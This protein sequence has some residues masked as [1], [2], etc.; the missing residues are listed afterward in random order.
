MRAQQSGDQH[1]VERGHGGEEFGQSVDRLGQQIDSHHAT[2]AR[3]GG[4]HCS[5][6]SGVVPGASSK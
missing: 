1:L 4:N 2:A 6:G 5:S 3:L